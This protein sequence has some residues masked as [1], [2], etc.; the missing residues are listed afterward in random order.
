[1]KQGDNLLRGGLPTMQQLRY[2]MELRKHEQKKG[3]IRSIAKKCGVQHS[4]VSRYF[5][6]CVEK[7]IL[8]QGYS[9]TDE[10]EQWLSDYKHLLKD[11]IVYLRYIGVPDREIKEK[12]QSM[13]ENLDYETLQRI[14]K[15]TQNENTLSTYEESAK[16]TIMRE[17]SYGEYWVDFCL[18]LAGY[19][20][21][22]LRPALLRHNKRGCFW[23]AKLR[24]PELEDDFLPE[25]ILCS[26]RGTEYTIL[27]R[28]GEFK[29]PFHLFQFDRLHQGGLRAML[30]VT[31]VLHKRTQILH[32]QGR[33]IVWL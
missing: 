4:S 12:V 31:I 21:V 6:I 17:I 33:F 23:C 13:V 32:K 14:I 15:V 9:F 26:V 28:A 29:I 19:E 18:Q 3:C 5:Q 7:G 24:Q 20:E 10:G 30:D 2:L 11:L 27:H 22:F 8:T 25:Q 1:M 16:R